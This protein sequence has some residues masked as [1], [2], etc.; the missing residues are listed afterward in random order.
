M[1]YNTT[2]LILN[3]AFGEIERHPEEFVENLKPFVNGGKFGLREARKNEIGE[4]DVSF[5]VGNYANAASVIDVAH[6]DST[7]VIMVGG[8]CATLL[9]EAYYTGGHHTKEGV[10]KALNQVLKD[11]GLKVISASEKKA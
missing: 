4:S 9:G 8:N 3:D 10:K 6:A 7:Q 2:V 1:G 5:G 11:Y